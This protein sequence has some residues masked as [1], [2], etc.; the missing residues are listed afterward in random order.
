MSLKA[1]NIL[2]LLCLGACLAQDNAPPNA[3]PRVAAHLQECY[4]RRDIFERDNRLPMTP[5]M[6]IEL[7]RKVEDS[8]GFTLNIQQF[9]TSL[10]HRM[11][12]DGIIREFRFLAP[13]P[14]NQL[15]SKAITSQSFSNSSGKR[16]R[17]KSRWH[18]QIQHERVQLSQTPRP[19]NPIDSRKCQPISDRFTH[20]RGTGKARA[21]AMSQHD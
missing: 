3:Q 13:P 7:L 15:N 20:N 8:P 10:L 18:P 6:L 11:K 4:R 9:T 5:N 14:H 2:V 21:R 1:V 19:L 17:R 16:H 12:Q